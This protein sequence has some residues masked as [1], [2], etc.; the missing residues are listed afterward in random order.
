[1][2]PCPLGLKVKSCLDREKS[3]SLEFI[4]TWIKGDWQITD[5]VE[6]NPVSLLP[7]C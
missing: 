4:S 3:E 7:T 6:K 1:V 5:T 2:I